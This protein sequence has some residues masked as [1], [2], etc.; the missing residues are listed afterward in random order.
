MRIIDQA[1]IMKSSENTFEIFNECECSCHKLNELDACFQ[2]ET[3][4]TNI[5]RCKKSIEY[6]NSILE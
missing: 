4:H 5:K 3:K 1:L 2:C 6:I